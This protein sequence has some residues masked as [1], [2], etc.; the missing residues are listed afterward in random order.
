MHNTNYASINITITARTIIPQENN[1]HIYQYA[2]FISKYLRPSSAAFS[3]PMKLVVYC[4]GYASNLIM[5]V[6]A[7]NGGYKLSVRVWNG[8]ENLY[9]SCY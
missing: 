9:F 4:G 6:I 5:I 3:N 7:F 8:L 2:E 1:L